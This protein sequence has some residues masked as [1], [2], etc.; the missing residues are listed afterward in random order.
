MVA[1]TG[2]QTGDPLDVIALVSP[3]RRRMAAALLVRHGSRGI[4]AALIGLAAVVQFFR[5]SPWPGQARVMN[6]VVVAVAYLL[7]VSI[8]TGIRIAS[9]WPSLAAAIRQADRALGLKNRLATAYEFADRPERIVCL[10]RTELRQC[11]QTTR[12]ADA[13]R[14]HVSRRQMAWLGFG[15]LLLVAAIVAPD[16][17]HNVA[18]SDARAGGPARQA[19]TATKSLLEQLGLQPPS[20]KTADLQPPAERQLRQVLQALQKQLSAAQTQHEQLKALTSAQNQVQ[21]LSDS[22]AQAKTDAQQ[23]AGA[24]RQGSTQQIAQALLSGDAAAVKQALQA[25]SLQTESMTLRQRAETARALEQAAN[26]APG[27]L[28]Q[29]LRQAAFDLSDNNPSAAK[30]ALA[31]AASQ[32]SQLEQQASAAGSDQQALSSL[33]KIQSDAANGTADNP[34][35]DCPPLGGA[36]SATIQAACR[37]AP[38]P[39]TTVASQAGGTARPG[40]AVAPE[41]GVST[42]RATGAAL[43][44]SGGSGRSGTPGAGTGSTS[45]GQSERTAG[46]SAQAGSGKAGRAGAQVQPGG[47]QAS[48]AGAAAAGGKAGS[49][50]GSGASGSTGSGL[51]SHAQTVYVPGSQLKGP[52]ITQAGPSGASVEVGSPGY[53]RL[54]QKYAASADTALG[55]VALP[56][57]LQS[58]VKRYF[59]TLQGTK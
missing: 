55:R 47:A 59:S 6:A 38:A 49:G 48:A 26:G 20:S 42:P 7:A 23:I 16:L 45:S 37:A 53:L 44:Q 17:R 58:T 33:Q 34:A 31:T 24:L 3:L 50:T 15:M 57:G 46:T 5:L 10:Q 19:A 22:A 51:Q 18:G 2:T 11:L 35:I 27:A 54:V 30:S 28:K 40:S 21:K 29:S 13:A 25:L 56:S 43:S 8:G 9:E 36:T 12:L 32:A 41:K 14:V 52:G 1:V 4:S 39:V